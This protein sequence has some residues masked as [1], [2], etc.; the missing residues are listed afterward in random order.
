MIVKR[1]KVGRKR[2]ESELIFLVVW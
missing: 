1:M 2:E